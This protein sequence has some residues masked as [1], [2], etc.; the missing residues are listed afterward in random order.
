MAAAT[1]LF[2]VMAVIACILLFIASLSATI[3]AADAYASNQYAIDAKIRG[4]HQYLAIAA[5]LGWSALAVLIVILIVA[6]VAGAF[7]ESE[8]SE[9]VL[10]K[11]EVT[12]S[13]LIASYKA[14]KELESGN[15]A[16]IVVLIILIMVAII[17]FIVGILA[18]IAAVDL[19]GVITRDDKVENA[20]TFAVVS[21]VSGVGG[22][23]IILVAVAAYIGV[24]AAKAA[25]IREIEAFEKR[26][27]DELGVKLK[28]D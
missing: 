5:A 20:Y 14:E 19:G 26:A 9:A 18:T 22:I 25:K 11:Q 2:I 7:K 8:V 1:V 17:T 3:S 4:A 27:E 23:G 16:Q 13:D 6:V 15:T 28:K 21:A 10:T 12:K 24:R